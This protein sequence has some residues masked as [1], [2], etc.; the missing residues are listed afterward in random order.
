MRDLLSGRLRTFTQSPGGVLL[1]SQP[2]QSVAVAAQQIG[3]DGRPLVEPGA[4]F[5]D[6]NYSLRV[7]SWNSITSVA[8]KIRVRLL[9]ADGRL[10]DQ[11]FDHTPNTNR[12]KATTDFALPVGFVLNAMVFANAGTPMIGQT[13]VQV[14]LIRGITGATLPISTLL[15]GYVTS[16]QAI[17]WP[18][19][20]L[21]DSLDGYGAVR[22]ILGTAQGVGNEF[23]ETVPTGARWQLLQLSTIFRATGGAGNRYP[24]L[25]IHA[26]VGFDALYFQPTAATNG[27]NWSITYGPTLTGAFDAVN[28]RIQSP[29]A[30]DLLLTGGDIFQSGTPGMLGTDSYDAPVYRVR[31]WLEAAA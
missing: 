22:T 20:P 14:Q 31:E 18:G 2:V 25:R 27:V 3:R 24:S 16:V 6:G 30:P 23:S 28:G 12:T 21:V 4:F 13:F 10:T 11:D 9:L 17:A 15:Q 5:L 8:L 26:S 1:E 19:S 7:N 29:I